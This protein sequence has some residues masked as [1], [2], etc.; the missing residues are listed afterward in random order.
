MSLLSSACRR[1]TPLQ[2]HRC[3]S[4]RSRHATSTGSPPRSGGDRVARHVRRR[5][6]VRWPRSRTRCCRRGAVVHRRQGD[7]RVSMARGPACGRP[8]R[9]PR[10][11]RGARVRPLVGTDRRHRIALG[12]VARAGGTVRPRP[13]VDAAVR[14]V[15]EPARLVGSRTGSSRRPSRRG[16]LV[17]TTTGISITACASSTAGSIVSGAG[18]DACADTFLAGGD[19]WMLHAWPVAGYDNTDGQF[20]TFNPKLC[21]PIAGT[22][23]IARC[24]DEPSFASTGVRGVR[25]CV[26][27]VRR[28][29]RA[30]GTAGT[31]RSR[32]PGRGT[33]SRCRLRAASRCRCSCRRRR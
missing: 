4:G 30:R 18:P 5:R 1:S 24:P 6:A 33:G 22:P 15:T 2:L 9:Q 23:D 25:R 11:D 31:R 27:R 26:P 29:C 21:P 3:A 17:R 32:C 8:I 12:A 13:A 10:R 16:S 19:L 28:R 14:R 20:A 7:L